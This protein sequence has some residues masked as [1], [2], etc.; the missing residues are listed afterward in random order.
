[1]LRRLAENLGLADRDGYVAA[2]RPPA[3][4]RETGREPQTEPAWVCGYDLLAGLCP[5][6]QLAAGRGAAPTRRC[7]SG[8]RLSGQAV[9][10][11]GH[12]APRAFN[13]IS[14]AVV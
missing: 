10:R 14:R 4:P 5:H 6:Y 2:S 7:R 12:R 11:S 3:A 9:G 1:M 8:E 13:Q